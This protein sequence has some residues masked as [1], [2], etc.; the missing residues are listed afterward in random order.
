MT[1]RVRLRVEGRFPERFI[2]RALARGV[3]FEAVERPGPRELL[4]TARTPDA[5]LVMALARELGLTAAVE[6][7]RGWRAALAAALER[8]TLIAG[9][10]LCAALVWL[11]SA[12][13]WLV[14]VAALDEALPPEA[15][16]ML[17]ERLDALGVRPGA[18]RAA[19]DPA[20][21]SA[22]LLSEFD[23][24]AYAGLRLRGV[25]ATVEYRL[26]DAPPA[27]YRPDEAGSLIAGRDAIVLSVQTLAGLACVR[28]GDVVRAG[29]LLISGEE[30][31]GAEET[32][33]VRALGEVVGRVWFTGRCEGALRETVRERTGRVRWSSALR[34][35]SWRWPLTEA[36][37][38]T[39]EDVETSV[40]PVGG[41]FLPM[42]IE[43]RTLFEVSERAVPADRT[44]FARTLE[45]RALAQARAKLPEGAR[46]TDRWTRTT[47]RGGTM[48]AEAVVEAAMNIAVEDMK[49]NPEP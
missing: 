4:V 47:E 7:R 20:A 24:L 48:T 12:R 30:R 41:L 28:P 26:E 31:A 43:R 25:R 34:L 23:R 16:A 1:D 33:P 40:L 10:A 5:R 29:Q 8:R 35:L 18:L 27:V 45:S 42:R 19:I 32:R 14:E 13:I 3:R 11:F 21:V 36:E 6:S 44:A 38:F 15:R 37:D 22:Q 9:L 39:S 49:R 46:E 2:E 17:A